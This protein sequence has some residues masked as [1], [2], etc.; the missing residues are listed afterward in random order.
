MSGISVAF[1]S[2]V[3]RMRSWQVKPKNNSAEWTSAINSNATPGDIQRG[4][5]AGFLAYRTKPPNPI[6]L[7]TEIDQALRGTKATGIRENE[8]HV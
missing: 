7:L 8:D 2:R 4:L 6:S 1:H 3:H 5:K